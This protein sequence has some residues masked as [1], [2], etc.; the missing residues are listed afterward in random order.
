[1][2]IPRFAAVVALALVACSE[3]PGG[4]CSGREAVQLLHSA[5]LQELEVVRAG[6]YTFLRGTNELGHIA[7][8]AGSDCGFDPVAIAGGIGLRPFRIFGD[9][10]DDPTLACD[11]S[12]GYL[13]RIDPD[14]E[15]APTLLAPNLDC[16]LIFRTERGAVASDHQARQL[17]LYPNF[18]DPSSARRITAAN[19][20]WSVWPA[21]DE[22]YYIATGARLRVQDLATGDDHP[23]LSGVAAYSATATHVLWRERTDT[24]V[25]PMRLFDRATGT[26]TYL[27]LYHED[28]DERAAGRDGRLRLG[29]AWRFDPGGTFVLHIPV[30]S[31]APMEAFDLA[32]RALEFPAWGQPR[33]LLPDGTMVVAIDRTH[34]AVRPGE[35][36]IALD[37]PVRDFAYDHLEV[38]D[39]HLERLDAGELYHV[40][41]DGSPARLIARGV[42]ERWTW[43]D[44]DHL[45]TLNG[46]ALITIQPVTAHRSVLVERVTDYLRVPD[47]GVYFQVA[48]ADDH[49]QNG[50]WYLPEA[51][52][53]PAPAACVNFT[54]CK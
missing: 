10:D 1:M 29:A 49:P 21:G 44:D 2:G 42:G 51:G 22:L 27:G 5:P 18:P 50:V 17:W 13:Y 38:I 53:R 28:E 16:R 3:D 36:P 52:L 20:G 24:T 19:T 39:D 12:G 26:S 31:D 15:A 33:Y 46:D 34:F 6:A 11:S 41:L 40:P 9:P 4:V 37:I 30:A 14:G 45:L 35:T 47:D 54:I 48:V 7:L 25:A 43:L 32:G 23:L 8:Y